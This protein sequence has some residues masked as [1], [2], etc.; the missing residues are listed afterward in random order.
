MADALD[1]LEAP[2]TGTP[3]PGG[4]TYREAHLAMEMLY[5]QHIVTSAEFVEV[6]PILD[7][8]NQTAELTVQLILSL[9]GKQ[10]LKRA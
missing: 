9:L 1:P 2:G 10:I 5:D 6:N 4:L 7:V 3:V 8:R